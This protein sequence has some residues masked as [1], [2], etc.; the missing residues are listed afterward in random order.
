MTCRRPTTRSQNGSSNASTT[1]SKREK[2][3]AASA[4]VFRGESS[5]RK[6][7]VPRLRTPSGTATTQRRAASSKASPRTRTTSSP[8]STAVT[9]WPRRTSRPS[10]NEATAD[11]SGPVASASPPFLLDL[12]SLQYSSLSQWCSESS[13][14]ARRRSPARFRGA[15]RTASPRRRPRAAAGAR[16]PARRRLRRPPRRARGAERPL[17]RGARAL[18]LGA[19]PSLS[20]TNQGGLLPR[21]ATQLE[22]GALTKFPR[23]VRRRVVVHPLRPELHVDAVHVDAV[24]SATQAVARFQHYCIEAAG[25]ESP[26]A[27]EACQSG[28]N[29]D[30]IDSAAALDLGSHRSR[31]PTL[32]L[33]RAAHRCPQANWQCTGSASRSEEEAPFEQHCEARLRAVAKLAP[34]AAPLPPLFALGR[35]FVELASCKTLASI[36][37]VVHGR[38]LRVR[39]A[40]TDARLPPTTGR[41]PSVP[42]RRALIPNATRRRTDNGANR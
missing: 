10:D 39:A 24:D 22:I 30:D 23:R 21:R 32:Y 12:T 41:H 40:S 7:G 28:T 6:A 36:R 9:A 31:P 29:D 5:G 13:S 17:R 42:P 35:W 2:P 20:S 27:G 19:G 38:S 33:R 25:F 8:V 14:C 34:A 4:C 1:F 11:A 15:R 37:A 3:T 16:R 26:R 18:D